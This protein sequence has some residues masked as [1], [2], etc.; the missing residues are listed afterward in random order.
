MANTF[1]DRYHTHRYAL[2]RLQWA[3]C[4]R[5]WLPGA[6]H[7]YGPCDAAGHG[8]RALGL[9]RL[10]SPGT[11]VPLQCRDAPRGPS[12]TASAREAATPAAAPAKAVRA[13]LPH[14]C[15]CLRV[16]PPPPT[17]RGGSAKG[18]GGCPWRVRHRRCRGPNA[19]PAVLGV[20]RAFYVA[21]LGAGPRSVGSCTRSASLGEGWSRKRS[22]PPSPFLPPSTSPPPPAF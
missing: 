2:L 8:H 4:C 7:M 5:V 17:G 18:G 11:C 16:P 9:H 21:R 12:G 19:L 1:R 6:Y 20:A 10:G 22:P 15:E 3:V 14:D 13:V